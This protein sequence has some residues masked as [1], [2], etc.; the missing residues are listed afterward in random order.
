MICIVALDYKNKKQA[1][2]TVDILGDT[3]Q[4]YKV[5]LELFLYCGISIIEELYKR[6]KYVFLDLKFHDITNTMCAAMRYV[7]EQNIF[8]TTVHISAGKQSL[9]ALQNLKEI[10][11][12]K[13][14]ILGVS[15]LTNLDNTDTHAIYN[16]NN[17]SQQVLQLASIAHQSGLDGIVCSV[18]ESKEIHKN[19]TN[20]I[21]VCPGIQYSYPKLQNKSST[22]QKITSNQKRISSP[23]NAVMAHANY[24]VVGRSITQ[25][26]KI[27]EVTQNILQE[28]KDAEKIAINNHE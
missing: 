25:A 8:M 28:L 7:L 24:I 17:T 13:T 20:M 14:K 16:T 15:V 12:S 5:G 4:H 9:I 18:H 21:T 23:Y 2:A 26:E 1:L 10:Y 22:K 27:L 19:Y 3:I 6:N 11:K